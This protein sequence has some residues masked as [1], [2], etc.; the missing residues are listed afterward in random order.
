MNNAKRV[1]VWE[2]IDIQAMCEEESEIPKLKVAAY[3]RVSTEQDEQQSSNI[4]VVIRPGNLS[5]STPTKV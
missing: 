2:P 4:S 3:A 5:V 1:T